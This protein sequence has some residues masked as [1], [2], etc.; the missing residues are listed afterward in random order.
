[1]EGGLYLIGYY[2]VPVYATADW[3]G[4]KNQY[5]LATVIKF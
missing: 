1:M 4:L 3:A 2:A 5:N